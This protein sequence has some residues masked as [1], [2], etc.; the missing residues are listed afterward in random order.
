MG[1]PEF[2][3]FEHMEASGITYL[4]T[5]FVQLAQVSSERLH[6]HELIHVVQWVTLGPERFLAAYADGLEKFG[7]RNSPLEV[8]ACNAETT[9]ASTHTPFD[10]EKLVRDELSRMGY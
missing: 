2:A 10:A 4:D 6:F 9:F 5:Y 8:M 1:L 7:Y 3:D